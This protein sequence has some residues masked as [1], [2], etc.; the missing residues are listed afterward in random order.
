MSE[1]LVR[2]TVDLISKREFIPYVLYCV[3]YVNRSGLVSQGCF[4]LYAVNKEGKRELLAFG[5]RTQGQHKHN[6][7]KANK[8]LEYLKEENLLPA[9][10]AISFENVQVPKHKLRSTNIRAVN[11]SLYR[12]LEK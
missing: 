5:I 8:V 1:C 12:I 2:R 3:S 6:E 4:D 10:I 7:R 11:T 9:G